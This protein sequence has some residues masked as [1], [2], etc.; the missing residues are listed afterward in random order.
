[1]LKK[2][3]GS[4]LYWFCFP[5]ASWTFAQGKRRSQH[6]QGGEGGQVSQAVIWDVGKFVG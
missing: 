1:M 3:Q 4:V 6:V 2:Q 5:R